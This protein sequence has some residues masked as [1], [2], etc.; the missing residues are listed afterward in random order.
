[1]PADRRLADC[2][3]IHRNTVAAVY[4]ELDRLALARRRPGSGTYVRRSLPKPARYASPDAVGTL[5][6]FV[7]FLDRQREAGGTAEDL[8][9]LLG[10]P[11]SG[12][13]KPRIAVIEPDRGLRS[14]FSVEILKAL[15]GVAVEGR[16]PAS[17]RRC[18]PGDLF[19]VARPDVAARLSLPAHALADLLVLRTAD[20]RPWRS[21]VRSLRPG[22]VMTL[23]TVSR[24]LRRHAQELL[25]S[26]IGDRIGLVRPLLARTA[27]VE[28]AVR[29]STLVLAD[30]VCARAIAPR[31]TRISGPRRPQLRIAETV[32][33]VWLGWLARYL[34]LSATEPR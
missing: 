34:G 31:W 29:V 6:A 2:L 5:L 4:S 33:P 12:R 25:A 28:R 7:A 27:E 18:V 15:P 3:G 10:R 30:S 22:D 13:G 24:A 1:M 8:N 9:S 19:L 32:C 11:S 14:L 16:T 26:E 21:A 20:P 23:L 17:A